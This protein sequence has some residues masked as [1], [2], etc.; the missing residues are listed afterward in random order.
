MTLQRPRTTFVLL[1]LCLIVVFDSLLSPNFQ[2][3]VHDFVR[4]N[5]NNI[6]I[7]DSVGDDE[8]AVLL[9]IEIESL[10][11]DLELDEN[12]NK[13][14]RLEIMEEGFGG[15][16]YDLNYMSAQQRNE[17]GGKTSLPNSDTRRT[18][19]NLID[20]KLPL[21]P[22][23]L[24]GVVDSTLIYN[25]ALAILVYDPADDKFILSYSTRH[26]WHAENPNVIMEYQSDGYPWIP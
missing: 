2:T 13:V 14:N 6:L 4:E 21:P 8:R 5:G 7:D 3:S 24:K 15:D 10:I 11:K 22:Y 23:N 26:P 1:S 17:M 19:H 25:G 9:G 12:N 16:D 20:S 18:Y